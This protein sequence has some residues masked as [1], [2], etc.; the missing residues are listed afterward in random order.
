MPVDRYLEKVSGAVHRGFCL[1]GGVRETNDSRRAMATPR[2]VL[3]YNPTPFPRFPNSRVV[4]EVL[5]ELGCGDVGTEAFGNG[6]EPP[7][8][9]PEVPGDL[10]PTDEKYNISY[11]SCFSGEIR[12]EC[13]RGLMLRHTCM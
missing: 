3:E 13:T 11:C 9:L 7:F 2:V 10:R 1:C 5:P 12:N 4:L 8:D 6:V